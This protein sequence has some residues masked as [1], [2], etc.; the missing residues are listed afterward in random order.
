[1]FIATAGVTI[2]AGTRLAYYGDIIAEKSGLGRTWI[3]LVLIAATTS[4]PELFT[5][6]S[7]TL[8]FKL[9]DI[10]VGDIL[11]SCMFNLVI[12]S[13]MDIVG[14]KTPISARA[15]QGHALT[16]GLG[17]LLMTIVGFSMAAGW[18]LPVLG[19]IGLGTPVLL[20]V[21]LFTVRISFIFERR[22]TEQQ[23]AELAE[24]RRY[25]LVSLRTALSRYAV[26][27][28]VVVVAASFLPRLG[29][30]IAV[31]TGLGQAFVGNLFIAIT[32][33]LPEIV[34]SL[35][36]VRLGAVDLAFGNVL[37]SNI[38]NMCILA[39]DDIFFA[40][41]PILAA[42]DPSHLLSVFAVVAMYAMLLVGLTYQALRKRLVLAW[43]TA[44][45]LVVYIV[46]LALLYLARAPLPPPALP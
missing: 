38:F 45:I 30:R 43:D 13:I 26:N 41:G 1:M 4:L 21:Y 40:P 46:T 5:G 12:L 31:E 37:G 24:E 10:A 36:A 39:L 35:A 14:G 2:F 11:G 22:R 6:I 34:V 20:A 25:D 44:G 29:E 15:H 7:S 23:A 19:W 8:V 27:A 17:L 42:A 16:I 32:T 33:S 9:P 28:L 18:A 3:G